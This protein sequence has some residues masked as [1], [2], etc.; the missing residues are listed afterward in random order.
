MNKALVRQWHNSLSPSPEMR[1][2]QEVRL[3]VPHVITSAPGPS[4]TKLTLAITGQLP[5]GALLG[6][7]I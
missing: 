2:F 4:D 6:R 5:P 1:A 7:V 3:P